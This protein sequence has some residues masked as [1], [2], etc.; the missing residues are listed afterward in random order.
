MTYVKL[1]SGLLSSVI[2]AGA[3]SGLLTY[4]NRGPELFFTNWGDAFIIA[5]PTAFILGLTVQPLIARLAVRIGGSGQSTPLG[6]P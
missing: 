1:I 2:M 5:W 6:S 3:M 4:L